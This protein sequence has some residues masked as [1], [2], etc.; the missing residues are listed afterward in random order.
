MW[1]PGLSSAEVWSRVCHEEA[2]KD[3]LMNVVIVSKK[4]VKDRSPLVSPLS[5]FMRYESQVFG[6]KEANID[7]PW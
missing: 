7:R 4:P 5:G 1:A 6:F 2:L 3:E